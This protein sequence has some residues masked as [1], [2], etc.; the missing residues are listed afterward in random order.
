MSGSKPLQQAG[1][2]VDNN[3]DHHGRMRLGKP[4]EH[5]RQHRFAIV[6]GRTNPH[7]PGNL[8]GHKPRNCFAVQCNQPPRI[9]KQHFAIMSQR[10]IAGIAQ[11]NRY[12]QLLFQPLDLHR[13]S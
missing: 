7:H 1:G 10:N 5:T 11:E 6:R 13:D 4:L 3:I 12:A 8:R 2:L 9:T